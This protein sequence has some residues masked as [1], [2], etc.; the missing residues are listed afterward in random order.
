MA[1]ALT[2]TL[3]VRVEVLVAYVSPQERLLK[4]I[5]NQIEHLTQE[6][7]SFTLTVVYDG[8]RYRLYIGQ[9]AGIV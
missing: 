9:N 4:Q 3:P 5:A 1:Q 2:A 7:N 8:S 6:R